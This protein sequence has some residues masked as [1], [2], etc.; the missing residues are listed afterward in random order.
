MEDCEYHL[1]RLLPHVFRQF[2]GGGIGEADLNL[3]RGI[4]RYYWT[5]NQLRL[6]QAVH[7][8]GG[9]QQ[10]GVEVLVLSGLYFPDPGTCAEAEEIALLIRPAQRMQAL[11]ALE[12]QGWGLQ[13]KLAELS[14]QHRLILSQADGRKLTLNWYASEHCRWSQCD[15]SFWGRSLEL[16]V[17]Q[18]STRRLCAGD[19]L[20]LACLQDTTTDSI[21]WLT[22][23]GRILR[24]P[25]EWDLVLD[26]TR[27]RRVVPLFNTRLLALQAALSGQ[28]PDWLM[29]E[30]RLT[31]VPWE[32]RCYFAGPSWL[33]PYLDYRRCRRPE[34][35]AHYLRRRWGLQRLR[36][37]P[38]YW[39]GRLALGGR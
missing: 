21:S 1:H 7:T 18:L 29:A 8:V 31:P 33:R 27:R 34:S 35:F 25:I 6:P 3:L 38:A 28:I 10:A 4:Y 36:Q 11:Q 15:D 19:M 23:A 17:Q 13:T 20:V 37:I 24:Q 30:L 16:D 14:I 2:E 26:E 9:L 22:N 5:L 32:D 12:K 39:F